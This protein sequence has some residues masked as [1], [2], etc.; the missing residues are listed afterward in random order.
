M[1]KSQLVEAIANEGQIS[2]DAAAKAL[3]AFTTVVG[4][5]LSTGGEVAITGF[6]KFSVSNR[7][8]RMG[9]NPQTGQPVQIQASK[10]P[11]FSGGAQLKAKVKGQG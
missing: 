6:G 1:N 5:E 11:K 8:A 9:R 4:N 10:A 7:A 3:E 2:R